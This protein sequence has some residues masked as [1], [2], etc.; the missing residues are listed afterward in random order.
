MTS[1]K[2]LVETLADFSVGSMLSKKG[3]TGA[4]NTDSC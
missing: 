4:A 3:S 1:D 2:H